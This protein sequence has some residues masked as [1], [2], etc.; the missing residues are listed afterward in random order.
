MKSGPSNQAT[1]S[2]SNNSD[3]MATS[4]T[5]DFGSSAPRSICAPSPRIARAGT[6]KPNIAVKEVGASSQ[7]VMS[8]DQEPACDNSTSNSYTSKSVSRR[9]L[10]ATLSSTKNSDRVVTSFTV[11]FGNSAPRSVCVSLRIVSTRTS[12]SN[13]VARRRQKALGVA[14]WK[15][16]WL[17]KATS[18]RRTLQPRRVRP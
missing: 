8:P 4:F 7:R 11:D 18:K 6:R 14:R 3:R 9:K 1:V 16:R 12:K 13:S 15:A 5:V 17:V 2:S 10:P